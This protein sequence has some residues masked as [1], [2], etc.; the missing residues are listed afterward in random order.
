M[1]QAVEKVSKLRK[2]CELTLHLGKEKSLK[3]KKG[4]KQKITKKE[5]Y[6]TRKRGERGEKDAEK[7]KKEMEL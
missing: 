2:I 4:W 7:Q 6:S 1:V 3:Y 5:R